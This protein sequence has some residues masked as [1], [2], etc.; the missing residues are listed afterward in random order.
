MSSY[1]FEGWLGE[2][3]DSVKGNM[4]WGEFEP[5]KWT[6]DDV[7]IEISHCGVC[8]SD[9]HQLS[10]GWGET[11]YPCVV[12][13]E[14]V[15]KAVKVGS[16]VKHIKQGDRVGVGAQAR[17]CLQKDC[18]D[19]TNNLEN[20]CAIG[21][22]NTYGS[23]YPGDEGK[24]Y[25]G[26]AD[27]N[28]THNRFVFNIPEGLSSAAAAPMLC[29]GITIFSPLKNYGCGPGKTVGIVGVGGIG[30]F[31]VLFAKALGADRV[32]G[33]SR[34]SD[35]RD[36]ALKLGADEYIATDEDKDWQ[37]KHRRSID[38]IVGTVSSAK[39][40][41][42]GYLGLLKTKG[43]YIQ[44]GAPDAGELPAINAF[45]LLTNGIKVGGSAIGSP[46]EIEEML[47]FAAD[48]KIEP[49]LNERPMKEAN[50]VVQDMTAG[51]A[52][53]R[54]VLVNEKHAKA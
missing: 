22:V 49:W 1:K 48:K 10:S 46:K 31:G 43:T 50:D 51:K 9:L 17:S 41:L 30:H 12:G 34:K 18:P 15:G 54:Y 27:Y 29:G 20:H 11:P 13:H 25:G 42:E 45:T 5:K 23:V 32:I 33:I 26:Y 40:P 37:T 3:K 35:K 36:D 39:M 14:I 53:Y 47:Q 8:G 38:L 16:N 28:R 6:E 2:D 24:S 21:T 44:I 52:R 7:D 4:R 19:C